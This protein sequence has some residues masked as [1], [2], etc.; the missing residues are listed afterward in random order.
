V[1]DSVSVRRGETTL[2]SDVSWQVG[3]DERWA[4]LG[5]NGSGKTTCLNIAGAQMH[6]TSGKARVLGNLLGRVDVR[7]LR[8]RISY[9]SAAVAR[10]LANEFSVGEVVLT[11]KESTLVPRWNKVTVEDEEL[12]ARILSR[13]EMLHLKNRGFGVISDGERQQTLLG[14]AL[15]GQPEMMLLDEPFAGLDMGARERLMGRLEHVYSVTKGAIVL[16]THHMEEIPPGTTH[17][18]L[19]RGGS[20]IASGPVGDVLT[21]ESLSETFGLALELSTSGRR[22]WCAAK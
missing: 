21:S 18:G 19:M 20:M 3:S 9:V 7:E 1:F 22:W 16:V 11:G 4:L 13:L 8:S 2:I 15:M 6:P 12:V 5:P 17:V 10:Q 14:R